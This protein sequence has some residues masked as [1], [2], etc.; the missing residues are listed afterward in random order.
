[1]KLFDTA[2]KLAWRVLDI[3]RSKTNFL[4]ITMVGEGN[5]HRFVT[6][7]A[8]LTFDGVEYVGSK[9]AVSDYKLSSDLSPT[10]VSI[11]L[12]SKDAS[13]K[14]A[15]LVTNPGNIELTIK[16]VY[17]ENLSSGVSDTLFVGTLQNISASE[18]S[19]ALSF[20]S[21]TILLENQLLR[22]T[23]KIGC[24]H[25]F[26]SH[27]CGIDIDNDSHNSLSFKHTTTI[28]SIN[29]GSRQVTL[30]SMASTAGGTYPDNYF[31]EGEFRLTKGG[32]T[33]YTY[34]FQQVGAVLTLLKIPTG[35]EV[36]D[37]IDIICGDDYSH[38]NCLA[39]HNN[40]NRF[41]GTPLIPVRNPSLDGITEEA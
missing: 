20:A 25:I 36:G 3:S 34:I 40:L 6:S 35:L 22:I 1:M 18:N 21:Y 29:T 26:G 32:Y 41:K 10:N 13:Y 27:T 7:R 38:E 28:S 12:S 30:D 9:A 11:L 23:T 16:R 17:K 5:T 4:L 31:R 19:I 24:N 33:Q 37:S 14:N 8:N 39:K 2:S 15:F